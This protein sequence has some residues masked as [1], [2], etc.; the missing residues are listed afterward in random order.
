[1]NK[2]LFSKK[3][4][5]FLLWTFA[6]LL[7]SAGKG[8][9]QTN[10][11]L[12]L[13]GGFE[14]AA[15]IVNGT[16]NS[17]PVATNWTKS[18]ATATI[19]SET[20]TVRSG[21][22][23]M[24]VT[25]TSS[26]LCRVF[27]PSMTVSASTTA[28]TVQYYRRSTSTTNSVQNQTGN[29]RGGTEQ[30][31]GTYSS[32]SAANTWQKVT[33]NPSVTTSA[34]TAAAHMLV[35][36]LGT[37]GDTY[38]DDFVLYEGGTDT[39][40]ANAP[41][42]SVVSSATTSSLSVSW[43]AAIGG[44]DGGGYLVVRGTSDPTTAPNVN[45]IYAVGNTI[46]A[47]M[48]VVYQGTGTSFTDSSLTDGTTYFYR[49]YTYDKAYNYSAALNGS[50]TTLISN[51][52]PVA[53]SVAISGTLNVGQ[54]LTGGYTYSDTDGDTQGTSTYQWYRAD[55]ASGTNGVAISG[56]TATTYT[57]Q[58][59]DVNKYIRFGVVPVAATG[60]SPG[61]EAFSSWQGPVTDP[62]AL[63]AT[64]STTGALTETNLTSE[65]LTI[66][67]SNT[68]FVDNVLATSNFTLNNA[69][70]GVTISD[71]QYNT[72][73][74][75]L[76][77]FAYNGTD[78]DTNVTN[79]SITIAGSELT[80]GAS[81]TTSTLPITALIETLSVSTIT[82]FGSQCLNLATTQ[83]FTVSGTNLKAGNVNLAALAGFT[84]SLDNVT[85]TSTITL[86]SSGGTLVATTVY[87]K[88]IP[89][90]V[91]S[92][93]GNIVVSGVGAPSV[94]RS[95]V[96]SG[97]NTIPTITTP[98]S[99]SIT[100]SSVVL[101]G[102]LTAIGCTDVTERG[103]YYSTTNGFAD[104]AGTKVSETSA[105]YATG[106]F[107]LNV[108]GLNSG[109]IYYYKAFATSSA[110]TTYSDQ[111]SFATLST[112]ANLSNLVLSAGTLVPTFDANTTT[113]VA[114]VSNA[115][116]SITV[117]STVQVAG[118][119]LQVRVNGGSYVGVTSGVAS[120]ALALN[121]GNNT[122]E[123]LVTAQ[124]GTTTKL[125]TVT[126]DRAQPPII[127]W[128]FFGQ[129]SPGTFAAT[130]INTNLDASNNL[131]LITR[132]PGASSSTGSNSFRTT[133]FQNNGISTSNTD[134]FQ[135]TIKPLTG[136]KLS[137]SSID[138]KLVGTATFATS[139]GVSNQFAYSTD[140]TNFTLINSAVVTIGTPV[141][142]PT[143]DLSGIP[144]LQNISANTTITIRYYASGQTSTGGWGFNSPD[145]NSNGLEVGGIVSLD[146]SPVIHTISNFTSFTQ[147]S[148]T[149]SAE[150]S[151]TV[152][153]D[154]LT[155][156]VVITPPM[157]YEIST[158][159]GGAFSAT[160]PI[161]LAVSGGNVVN[162]PV[163]IY[164][165]Q[166]A[167][168]LGPISGN[169]SLTSSGATTKTV[170]VSGVRTGR[171]YSKATGDLNVLSTWGVET[172]GTGTAPASF[173]SEGAIYEIRNRATA[174]I[175]ANWTVSGASSKVVLGDGSNAVD[176]I[177]PSTFSLSGTIDISNQAELTIQNTTLPTFGVLA[178]QSSIEFNN[179]SITMP[180]TLSY[181]NL[182]LS[183]TGIKTF[184]G[185][186]TTINGNLILDNTEINGGSGP[187]STINIL[188]NIEYIGT[189][190]P[191]V[192]AN[193]ITLQTSGASAGTQTINANNN[194]LRWFRITSTTANTIVVNNA[195]NVLLGNASGG[196]ITLVNNSVLDLSG[197]NLQ[198]FN[199]SSTTAAFVLNTSG[200]IA[201]NDN[202]NFLIERTG[203]GSLG[204]LHFKSD[205]NTLGSFTYNHT[206]ATNTITIGNTLNIA[207]VLEVQNGTIQSNGNIVLKSTNSSS[208]RVAPVGVGASITG[209]VVVERH[210]PAKRA[211]RLLTAPI[212]GT[213]NTSIFAN[214]QGTN[215]E[216]I[217]L[218]N[219]NGGG[220]TGLEVG[221]Q[222][223]IFSYNGGWAAVNNTNTTP[224]FGA[225]Q[226]N[227]FL[228]FATGPHGSANITPGA[229]P[230][231]PAT[232][233]T[234][235]PKGGLIT[236][237]V[238]T[239]L[240]ANQFQLIGNPYASALDTEA[241]IGSNPDA[242]I[243]MLD[244]T[245][246]SFG[247]YV[248]Y[249]G[250]NWAPSTPDAADKNI[251][252][253]QGFF[254]RSA[255]TSFA[256][257]EAHKVSGSSDTWFARDAAPLSADKIRVLLYKPE[258]GNWKLADGV[259]SVHSSVGNDAVDAADANK[260][261]NFNENI[262]F[263][264]GATNLAIEYR[265]MPEAGTQQPLRM[266][267][268]TAQPYQLRVRTEGYVN[269]TLQPYLEDTASGT[270]T[271]IPTDGSDLIVS[272]TGIVATTSTPDNRFRIVYPTT[273]GV[274]DIMALP[275]S[276][277]PN[278]VTE[279]A[280]TVLLKETTAAQYAL[281]N[282]LGQE[283]QKGTLS[284]LHNT[285]PVGTLQHGIYVLQVRQEGKVF[286]T[287]LILK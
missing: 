72:S 41:T 107:I 177:I 235:R 139:P 230:T 71:V 134:Y 272:F 48:T 112:N 64:L 111:A 262:A 159:T 188:G 184:A 116:S 6:L 175:G 13:N 39:T 135:I 45:G 62:T 276:V 238:T 196:G 68:T 166:V 92:Y 207:N 251:Q 106:I 216:G 285:I 274:D 2:I 137:L 197:N 84:Y 233:T 171:Y 3:T 154:N 269:S 271:A 115:N 85:F 99:A 200:V 173:T 161:N 17:A 30:A 141:N 256:I 219:P 178:S 77:T 105:S 47:G 136:Y 81:L 128:N 237:T 270:L 146:N 12:G 149:P 185:G 23:S 88:F 259:L 218:W 147:T 104:G 59:A 124:D 123:V 168:D 224:L 287:K 203:S 250:T 35:K 258:S 89:T 83:T 148:S 86:P 253:G 100:T 204:T 117:T 199:S 257:N 61:V 279:G 225:T 189:V 27:S 210:I 22:K 215:N 97:I 165:R 209:N 94:N 170:A 231:T 18:T 265:G 222:S 28:W 54:I 80:S 172:D 73:T 221:P 74:S 152:S 167:V 87:V 226:N 34:T 49:I 42:S 120:G 32:V 138:A 114:S 223:N 182:K 58:A 176:F 247:G 242:K 252:S 236:G 110:G 51:A 234:L 155:D 249:D 241:L 286:T 130:T 179:V 201:V 261:S 95:V 227:A 206:G 246:G 244:P 263:R 211:W 127:A 163:T 169:I 195:S 264:N 131:S 186:T 217:L 183:G 31:N 190:T 193:S 266:T 277:Y 240:T 205:A 67:L 21:S 192:D 118:A 142:L 113:Y 8:L 20:G 70:A 16:T 228:V 273:L 260:I 156:N 56:A 129:S 101:G 140:G 133:G 63:T 282:V 180:N 268:T 122:I 108:T 280:F 254:V 53:S 10:S 7:L 158:T 232:A 98:T 5:A 229:D 57:L 162:E 212:K 255:S 78:F 44:E 1:M 33:Y 157:G 25:S 194:V 15:I 160:N 9:A 38:Y 11:Y 26:T 65:I 19:A 275:V 126:V 60:T 75:V 214:W 119:T 151:F 198:L 29:Y 24:K 191:P 121:V 187:F 79:L 181:A 267:G 150:Q 14:G 82:D 284:S 69:P 102:N 43:T 96:G 144:E 283:V 213:T 243:W 93:N 220:A 103:I 248:T 91:Q 36:G 76:L 202:T 143:V 281:V 55:D 174:T 132:G 278:P 239:T 245:L 46:A 37:G 109:T 90:L 66:D 40:P 145:S 125:Y 52:A 153:G 208:A 164:V 50:G 4:P